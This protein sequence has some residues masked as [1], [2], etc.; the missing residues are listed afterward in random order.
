MKSLT[1]LDLLKKEKLLI[2]SRGINK[3]KMLRAAEALADSGVRFLETTFD[4]TLEPCVDE[5]AEKIRFLREHLGDRMHIGAGT[6]LSVN[7]VHAAY[8]AGCEYIISPNTNEA[9]IKETKRLGMLSIPGAMTPTEIC[10]AWDL[11]ADIIKLFPADDVG[12][13]FIT[14]I[15]GP[16]PHIPLMATGGVNPQTIPELLGRGITCFGTGITV[17]RRDLIEA[18]NY[19]AIAQLAKDHLD[20]IKNAE[21]K[22][23]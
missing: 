15:R 20:A 7:E 19:A 2:I 23:F 8:E 17:L 5:N 16:L 14:N 18:E 6:V 22:N 12:M 1:V 10:Q 11:G 21:H 13:H 9:V 4:H 3:E